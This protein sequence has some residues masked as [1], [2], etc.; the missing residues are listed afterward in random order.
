MSGPVRELLRVIDGAAEVA[1][2][3]ERKRTLEAIER[4]RE[5]IAVVFNEAVGDD[6][7]AA[8]LGDMPLVSMHAALD[9]LKRELAPT[10]PP[11]DGP[12]G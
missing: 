10:P 1:T 5:R 6:P 11:E 4:V 3:R 7:M 2:A 9:A 12:R 8:L